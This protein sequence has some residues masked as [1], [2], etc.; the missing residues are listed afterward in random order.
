MRAEPE[1][2]IR[3]RVRPW[4][5]ID[6]AVTAEGALEVRQRGERDFLIAVGGRVLMTSAAH[7]SEDAL[8]H[9]GCAGLDRASRPHVLLGGLG[10]G[11]TLRAALDRLPHGARVAVVELNPAVVAWCRGPLAALTRRATDDPRVSVRIGDVC[12]AIAAAP[13]ARYDAILLDLYEGPHQATNGPADPV[14][15]AAALGRAWRSLRPG[16]LL[17]VWSEEGDRSFELRL[18]AAGFQVQKRHAPRGGRAHVIYVATRPRLQRA[19]GSSRR[20]RS[21]F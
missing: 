3:W 17:A 19:G 21:G 7:R 18:A 20:R 4:R 16:G 13:A 5:V 1:R 8:A 6:T 12:A 11:Y 2:D 9:L 14:Y 10:M 15:G